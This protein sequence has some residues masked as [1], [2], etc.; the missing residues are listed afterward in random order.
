M[1]KSLLISSAS[2]LLMTGAAHA[3]S[4]CQDYSWPQDVPAQP[5]DQP[6]F[7]ALLRCYGHDD[8][9][10]TEFFGK[11]YNSIPK[12]EGSLLRWYRI[13]TT[14]VGTL[15]RSENIQRNLA[16]QFLARI[17]KLGSQRKALEG[18]IKDLEQK[19]S[20]AAAASSAL[21]GQMSSLSAERDVARAKLDDHKRVVDTLEQERRSIA[22]KLEAA[23]K[24]ETAAV[25]EMESANAER[26]AAF[27]VNG[28]LQLQL[29]AL[30]KQVETS[31]SEQ[32]AAKKQVLEVE[33]A[34][35]AKHTD[36]T[37]EQA[38]VAD[39]QLRLSNLTSDLSLKVEVAARQ[40]AEIQQLSDEMDALKQSLSLMTEEK[41]ALEQRLSEAN[42]AQEQ[43]LKKLAAQESALKAAT[44]KVASL[45]KSAQQLTVSNAELSKNL[46]DTTAQRDALEQQVK[47]LTASVEAN[48]AQIAGLEQSIANQAA[49]MAQKQGIIESLSNDKQNLE[50][51]E[52]ELKRHNEEIEVRLAALELDKT[53]LEQIVG[54]LNGIVQSLEGENDTLEA[55]VAALS[56]ENEKLMGQIGRLT[57]QND[58]LAETTDLLYDQRLDFAEACTELTS[59]I[60]AMEVDQN[61]CLLPNSVTFVTNSADL[62]LEGSEMVRQVARSL[63]EVTGEFPPLEWRIEIAGHTDSRPIR[64][65]SYPSNWELS[66]ARALAV[67]LVMIDEYQVAVAGGGTVVDLPK[68]LAP[69]G[70]A[71][72]HPIDPGTT[73]EALERN[74]RTEFRLVN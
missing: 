17:D 38:T 72:M 2:V 5:M 43:L 56:G 26:D 21:D 71:D 68:R 8:P 22:Q 32:A 39:L 45:E 42:S 6:E 69:V 3:A 13:L 62:T 14:S 47:D 63:M 10:A 46:E 18:T 19:L 33:A 35:A 57:T 34:L 1:L 16:D 31:L 61:T 41:A 36:L 53:S 52:Q 74:R 30:Q 73:P 55:N 48:A 54:N 51:L 37:T 65:G 28:R 15:A 59:T 24:S 20:D 11:L 66:Y 40:V 49:D 50:R 27:T 12:D 7:E 4:Q 9:G 25:S 23:T 70:F 29:D 44:A 67:T 58:R 64:G 60:P